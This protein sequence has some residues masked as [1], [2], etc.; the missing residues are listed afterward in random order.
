MIQVRPLVPFAADPAFFAEDGVVRKMLLEGGNDRDLALAIGAGD[1]VVAGLDVGVFLAELLP[2]PQKDDRPEPLAAS[3]AASTSCTARH[4][5]G[6]GRRIPP[7]SKMAMRGNA[8][9][10]I[11]VD[12][13]KFGWDRWVVVTLRHSTLP[14]YEEFA[15]EIALDATPLSALKDLGTRD[16]LSLTGQ[17]A[18]HQAF[19]QF[20]GV[21]DAAFDPNEWAVV[22]KR[23]TDCRLVRVAA[24]SA[25]EPPPLLTSIQQFASAIAALPLD[26]FRQSWGRA[27]TAYHEIDSRLRN[28]VAADLR[29]LRCAALGS[30]VAPGT[31]SLRALQP[32]ST[33][34]WRAPADLRAFR[35]LAAIDRTV[36]ILGDDASPLTRY[37]GIANL[38]M[39][40]SVSETEIVER[41]L[42]GPLRIARSS[43][44]TSTR[45]MTRRVALSTC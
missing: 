3:I 4:S 15:S 26:V 5:T 17:F 33:G 30:V 6:F 9:R 12:V 11:R 23:S 24:R 42:A 37:S 8:R 2:M 44:R 16:R 38:E 13:Q 1:P 41:V 29:W 18:A 43:S 32:M 25:E 35:A 45:S 10:A 39:Q 20:A 36:T 40:S 28:D 27:E 19:L 22:R 14:W 31:E 34:R 21:R 7:L